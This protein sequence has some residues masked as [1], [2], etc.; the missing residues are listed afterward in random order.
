MYYDDTRTMI[1]LVSD[2]GD[3]LLMLTQGCFVGGQTTNTALF[4]GTKVR[5]FDRTY[6]I[7]KDGWDLNGRMVHRF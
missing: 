5:Y 4:E 6:Q 3:K 1:R 7:R 2:K